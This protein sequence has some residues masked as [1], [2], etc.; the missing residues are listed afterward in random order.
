MTDRVDNV[1]STVGGVTERARVCVDL[2]QTFA[3][4]ENEGAEA[5]PE[6]A[7]AALAALR[8]LAERSPEAVEELMEELETLV[9]RAEEIETR[10]D[11]PIADPEFRS[12]AQRVASRAVALC[13]T[14]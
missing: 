11:S 5:D 8:T 7:L 2:A 14:G 1:R 3:A 6:Q 13:A 12:A 4:I 10:G 9:R